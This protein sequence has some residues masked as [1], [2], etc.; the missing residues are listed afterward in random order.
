MLLLDSSD[1]QRLAQHLKHLTRIS[2]ALSRE[3][4]INRLLEMILSEARA[5]SNADAGT[6]YILDIDEKKLKFAILQN[7]ALGTRRGGTSGQPVALPDVALYTTDGKP[8]HANVS[9]YAALTGQIVNI[10]DVYESDGFDF[11]GPRQYDEATGYRSQSML[12]IPMLNHMDETIGVLQ[13]LNAKD[14][15]TQTAVRFSESYVDVIAALA[16]QAA[17]ALSNTQLIQELKSL[18]HAF[19]QS[20]ATA[21]DEKS[22]YTGGHIR[23]VVALAMMLAEAVNQTDHLPFRD[24]ALNDDEIAELR[25]AAWMHDVGKITTPDHIIDK[26]TKLQGFHDR[27]DAVTERFHVLAA[28]IE[29]RYLREKVRLLERSTHPLPELEHL[30]Q[31][32]AA[33]MDAIYDD[34][35][36]TR[37]CNEPTNPLSNSDISR[38][39]AI[40]DRTIS[41]NGRERPLLSE[42]ELEHLS[43][44]NGTLSS[45]ERQIVSNHAQMTL[46]ILTQVPFPRQLSQV[47]VFAGTHH[48]R[49]DGSGYPHQLGQDD[50]PLQSRIMAIADVFEA[51]TAKDRPYKQPMC[52]SK[53]L[54]IMSRM[55]ADGHIDPDLFDL[56]IARGL[57]LVYARKEMSP[58]QIDVGN[59]SSN[60]PN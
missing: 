5:L 18:L 35:S 44:A 2:L 42:D 38:L 23:R 13:L 47:P 4:D 45:K 28:E 17:V 7:D 46:K 6:L 32:M 19:T 10:A 26:A 40:A 25:M 41:I 50:L 53:A 39:Q 14:P 52:L 58:D 57:H 8:N 3:K 43:I 59:G 16:S 60:R 30:N 34:L 51:L 29:N 37:Q 48:E 15:E 11:T 22:P 24:V 21:L 36:F 56:F 31:R 20:I 49:L 9:S 12:V 33:E 55:K 54:D 1:Q 27:I